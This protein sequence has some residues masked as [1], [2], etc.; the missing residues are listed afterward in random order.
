MR[1][2]HKALLQDALDDGARHIRD[3]EEWDKEKRD[4]K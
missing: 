2:L 1:L 3:L 4:Q